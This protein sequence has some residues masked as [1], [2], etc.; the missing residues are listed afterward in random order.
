MDTNRWDRLESLFFAALDH[1][2][3]GRVAF[4]EEACEGDPEVRREVEAMLAAHEPDHT[5]VLE[6]RLLSDEAEPLAGH[7]GPYRLLERLGRGGMGEVFLAERDDAQFQRRV[8]LKLVKRGMDT[9]AILRRFR[10]ERQ[11]LAA[12][13]HPGIAH[14]YDGG[15]AEDGRPYFALEYVEGGVPID[16]YCDANHLPIPARLRLFQRVCEAVQ[17]AHQNLVVHRDLKPGNILVSQTGEVKLLDFGIAKLLDPDLA[18]YSIAQTQAEVRIMTPEYAAPEQVR[19]EPITTA[20]DGYQLGVLLYELLTGHRPYRLNT[21]ATDEI[22]RVICEEEPERP[23]TAVGRTQ[24]KRTTDATPVTPETVSLARATVPEVLRRRLRGDLDTIVLKALQKDPQRRYTSVKAL[25]D[26]VQRFLDGHPV[27]A[28]PD[29]VGYRVSKFVRRHTVGVGVTVLVFVLLLSFG[30]TMAVQNARIARQAEEIARERDAATEVAAFLTGVFQMADPTTSRGEVVTA[31]ELLDGGAARIETD[32]AAQPAVQARM[33]QTMGDVYLS[34]AQYAQADSLLHRSLML[35]QQMFGA[36]HPEVAEALVALGL[37]AVHRKEVAAADS[38]LAAALVMQ[39]Q[40]LGDGHPATAR[41]MN[42]HAGVLAE[43]GRLEAAE[44]LNREALAILQAEGGSSAAV[45]EAMSDLAT[46]LRLADQYEEAET[47]L[48]DALAIHRAQHGERH[49]AVA[50]GMGKLALL[51][52]KQARYEEAEALLHEAMVLNR[53]LYG[54]A[55]PEIASALSELAGVVKDQG[56]YERAVVLY[57][58]A[59]GITRAVYGTQSVNVAQQTNNLATA[60]IYLGDMATA[61][62]LIEEA[63]PVAERIIG[64]VHPMTASMRNN[65]SYVL[66]QMNDRPGAE[67]ELR[68][69]LAIETSLYGEEHTEVAMTTASLATL[70]WEQGVYEEAEQLART[71]L[72][73]RRKLLPPDHPDLANSIYGVAAMI[74]DRVPEEAEPLLR[75]V[76]AIRQAAFSKEDMRVVLATGRLG[77]CLRRLG[78]YDE[79]E[80]LLLA[81]YAMANE[82][83]GPDHWLTQYQLDFL[84]ALYGALRRPDEQARYRALQVAA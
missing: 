22:A 15:M 70:L 7:I 35:R 31:R 74:V 14:L 69:V 77:D 43:A 2:A 36:T 42:H 8:A 59:L 72:A 57:D 10:Q 84:I 58:S 1:P 38:L 51:L 26:D 16:A 19:G 81:S 27:E 75:E 20:T 54:H 5:L 40:V 32:L 50:A 9:D 4:L 52:R 39:R 56:D 55:H 41:T 34:L 25:A 44:A 12:L 45:A 53:Q 65:L 48:R 30:L 24:E 62:R 29:S 82:T 33:M 66:G 21:R 37:L 11:I 67:R 80:S 18:P 46:T 49:T 6:R 78:R 83:Q 79:A 64:E 68:K 23:S 63:L 13:A 60:Y 76:L 71:A 28:Q 61:R 73:L 3:E 47:L 17:F